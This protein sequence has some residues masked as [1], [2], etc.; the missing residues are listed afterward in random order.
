MCYKSVASGQVLYN[1]SHVLV[2]AF[3]SDRDKS[4]FDL[5]YF[6]KC[7]GV[8]RSLLS[9]LNVTFILRCTFIYDI[10]IDLIVCLIFLTKQLLFWNQDISAADVFNK[11]PLCL[12]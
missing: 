12:A 4:R 2:L 3:I 5:K 8:L 7:V 1:F 6:L 11:T 10:V 9:G